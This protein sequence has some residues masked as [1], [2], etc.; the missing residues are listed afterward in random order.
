MNWSAY[1][2]FLLFAAGLVLIPGPDFAVVTKNTL[3]GGRR[4]GRFTALGVCTSNALQG[5][6][7]V[8]GLSA[9]VMHAQPVFQ[10]I[11]WAGV[12]YLAVLGIQAL[13]SAVRGRPDWPGAA[14]RSGAAFGGWRQGF[15]SNITNPKVLIFYL[16]VL[17]QFLRPGE[18]PAW[19]LAFAWSHALLSLIYL[20]AL[21]TG[22]A[23]IRR[24]LTSRRT[25]RAMDGTTGVLLLGFSARMAAEQT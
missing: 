8:S 7:A 15:L 24:L 5:T 9:I 22:L 18:A 2:A 21:S 14:E 6:V 16:A 19:L 17:P 1:G 23:R 25:R 4:R 20:I 12:C 13:V 3:A 10:A 11:K